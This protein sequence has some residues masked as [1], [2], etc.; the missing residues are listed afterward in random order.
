MIAKILINTA[1]K[2]L[3][4]VYDYKVPDSL[5]DQ[6]QIGKRVEVNFGKSRKDNEEGIIVKLEEDKDEAN[7]KYKLKE[8]ISV[9]DEVSY[10]NEER[11][12]FAKYIS[13]MYFCN[14]YDALKLM[15][16]PGTSSKNSKKSL[17]TKQE[18]IV[19][20]AKSEEEIRNGYR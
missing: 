11:L 4:K 7:R 8:I 1:V 15:L 9:L 13:Y 18:S 6:V 14:V 19:V 3:N 12:K 2:T 10:I 20:L 5:L 17:N 16:P